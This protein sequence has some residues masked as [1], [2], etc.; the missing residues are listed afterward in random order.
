M[1]RFSLLAALTVVISASVYAQ[2]Q[3]FEPAVPRALP[4][5]R[6]DPA[7][8]L[9]ETMPPELVQNVRRH[10]MDADAR[11]CLQLAAN[12][13]VHRCAEK[14]RPRVASAAKAPKPASAMTPADMLRSP[15][16]SAIPTGAPRASDVAKAASPLD[17]T[18]SVSLTKPTEAG[19]PAK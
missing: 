14:Y 7:G 10:A 15:A 2:G 5:Q 18:K 4:E 11:H 13:E 6:V 3:V 17:A 1:T 16:E 19:K 9:Q 8:Q 12:Q